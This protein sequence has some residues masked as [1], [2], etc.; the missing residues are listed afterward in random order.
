MAT[1][2][3]SVNAEDRKTRTQKAL[4]EMSVSI[5]GGAITTFGSVVMLLAAKFGVFFKFGVFISLTIPF[6]LLYSMLFFPALLHAIGPQNKC[7]DIRYYCCRKCMKND[8]QK[9][10]QIVRHNG[11][12]MTR[13]SSTIVPTQKT[14]K[15]SSSTNMMMMV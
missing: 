2:Y 6:S 13:E 11:N 5:L 9:N 3:I 4:A 14:Y 8:G 15:K 1:H 10:P 12:V 7:G